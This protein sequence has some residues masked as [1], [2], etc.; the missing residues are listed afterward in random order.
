MKDSEIFSARERE[1]LDLWGVMAPPAGFAAR[2]LADAG[3]VAPAAP[4][5]GSRGMAA[6]AMVALAL[7]G[8]WSLRGLV[9]G[10]DGAGAA[11]SR[12]PGG[13]I[14]TPDGGPR[15]EVNDGVSG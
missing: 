9:R 6:A 5:R 14:A 1:A 7:G 4:A 13:F 10:G 11:P 8:L 2:V 3:P 15:P 12:D